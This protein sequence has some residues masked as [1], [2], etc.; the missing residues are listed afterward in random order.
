[1]I[2]FKTAR[3]GDEIL[4]V[5]GRQVCSGVNPMSEAIKWVEKIPTPTGKHTLVCGAGS[6]FHIEQLAHTYSDVNFTVL[7]FNSE[8]VEYLQR[9]YSK[10]KNI[11]IISGRQCSDFGMNLDIRHAVSTRYQVLSFFP[12]CSIDSNRYSE[13]ISFLL[14]R[15]EAGFLWICMVRKEFN[16]YVQSEEHSGARL[17]LLSEERAISIKDLKKWHTSAVPVSD[18]DDHSMKMKSLGELIV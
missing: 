5:N 7:D 15:S 6:G 10:F 2:T 8:I 17:R 16:S 12:A 3:S 14:G 4:L 18:V 13:L 11:K 1:M 9:K